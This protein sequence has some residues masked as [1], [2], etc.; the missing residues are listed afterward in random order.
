MNRAFYLAGWGY[1][2]IAALA[3]LRPTVTGEPVYGPDPLVQ[4][5]GSD[6]ASWFQ[7]TKPFCNALEVEVRIAH[8][9]PP[10]SVDGTGF[11][12]A[13]LALAG[14]I[15]AA[16]TR[17]DALPAENR[18]DAAGIVFGVGHPV[19]DMGG[20]ASAGPI[21]RLVV[22]YQPWNYMALY[23]A[24]ISYYELGEATLAREHLEKFLQAYNVQD[25][26]RSNATT[27]LSRLGERQ[28]E[29]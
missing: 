8:D 14:K 3:L 13:C 17:I 11:G 4:F 12:A 24:G 9:P 7:R 19:A 28:L 6:G 5:G 20:D 1:V 29:R 21:M 27:V 23:H 2:A 18:A 10:A 25:G 15:D 22:E 16:R 26:W